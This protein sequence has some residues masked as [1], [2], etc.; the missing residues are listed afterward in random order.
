MLTVLPALDFGYL[1]KYFFFVVKTVL[2]IFDCFGYFSFFVFL[3]LFF[4]LSLFRHCFFSHF[5]FIYS[6]FSLFFF[7]L[8][9]F[10]LTLEFLCPCFLIFK[11][12]FFQMT[13]T[14]FNC[15]QFCACCIKKCLKNDQM[16]IILLSQML[17]EFLPQVLDLFNSQ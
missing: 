11:L 13:V 16:A 17:V 4:L 15:D 12:Y 7:L 2:I 3:F 5:H 10:L 1:A 9:Q 6:L 8:L 14:T